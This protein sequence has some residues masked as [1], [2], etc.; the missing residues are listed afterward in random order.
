M[1]LYIFWE[2]FPETD[3]DAK[4]SNS[5]YVNGNEDDLKDALYNHVS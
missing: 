1:A 2:I 4:I 3:T 5:K